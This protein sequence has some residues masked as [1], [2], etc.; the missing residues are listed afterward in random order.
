MTAVSVIV[1]ATGGAPTLAECVAGLRAGTRSADEV[2]V[3]TDAPAAGAAAARNDG[4]Q[5]ASGDVLVFVDADVVMKP[6]ALS[7]VRREL[8]GDRPPVAVFGSYADDAYAGDAVSAFRN[9]SLVVAHRR[10][11]GY[12]M[13]WSGLCAVSADA[14]AAAGRFSTAGEVAHVE[15]IDLGAR[16]AQLGEVRFVPSLQGTHVK[17]WRLRQMLAT[18]AAQ[19]RRFARLRERYPRLGEGG[20]AGGA[21]AATD[22]LAV[23]LVG[24]LAARRPRLAACAAC[25][26]V[27]ANARLFRLVVAHAGVPAAALALPLLVVQHVATLAAASAEVARS[28]R[29]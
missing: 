19:A 1:P 27:A 18:D 3:V 12:G 15:D 22:A 20:D 11:P 13:F 16:L 25:A 10:T 14:F 28:D 2:I 21:S 26:I 5:R 24:A 4:A 9:L 6:D 29:S 7:I 8:T 23:L 17:R